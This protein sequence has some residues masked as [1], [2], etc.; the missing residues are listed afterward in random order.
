MLSI[1]DTEPLDVAKEVPLDA[2][3]MRDEM[4]AELNDVSG[5]QEPTSLEED[6]L[7]IIIRLGLFD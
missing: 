7:L 4:M 6:D 3:R 5:K 2:Q 1:G